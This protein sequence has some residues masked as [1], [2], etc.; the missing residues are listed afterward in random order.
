V[1]AEPETGPGPDA[2]GWHGWTMPWPPPT[3][4]VVMAEVTDTFLWNRSPDRD[5]FADDYVLHPE[6][7]GVTTGLAERL[8]SWNDRYGV[9]MVDAAW[10]DEGWSL[11]HDLQREF[12]RRG[13]D[14]EVLF[15]EV[16]GHERAVRD[17]RRRPRRS[18]P[19]SSRG[20]S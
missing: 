18:G 10:W 13:V 6:V 20:T 2:E 17:G 15:H 5:P 16:D 3:T 9:D 11:A 14:V 19:G 4:I 8:T 1:S 12:A 7:L